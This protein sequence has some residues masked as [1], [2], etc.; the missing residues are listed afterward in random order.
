MQ[1][2]KPT[3]KVLLESA[4]RLSKPNIF[5]QGAGALDLMAAYKLL[6]EYSPRASLIPP[7]LDL[8]DCPYMWPY[9]S[10]PLYHSA[11]PVMVNVTI[12][13]GMGV[14]G[15][16]SRVAWKPHGEWGHALE[17]KAELPDSLWPWSGQMGLSLTVREEG[18]DLEDIITG[19]IQLTVQS[20]PGPGEINPRRSDLQLEVRVRVIPTPV[21][22]KRL[23]W[24]Q[25]HS[26][27]YPSAYAPRDYLG[28]GSES[29]ILDR[30][31][32]H[33]H[34]NFKSLFEKLIAAGYY[35]EILGS[36]WTCFNASQYGALLLVDSE[37]EFF[38]EEMEK[39]E[40]DIRA[41]GLSLVVFADWFS[42]TIMEQVSFV[43]DNTRILW[44]PVTGG[45]NIPA[46]NE[47]L[48]RFGMALGGQV[49]DGVIDLP[50]GKVHMASGNALARMP[51]GSLVVHTPEIPAQ[52]LP[53]NHNTL[54]WQPPIHLDIAIIGALDSNLYPPSV[55]KGTRPGVAGDNQP[56]NQPANQDF[57]DDSL[58]VQR[59]SP[60]A[61][62]SGGAWGESER[63]PQQ[64]EG[65]P[66]ERNGGKRGTPNII[67][68][69]VQHQLKEFPAAEVGQGSSVRGGNSFGTRRG[70]QGTFNEGDTVLGPGLGME[71]PGEVEV[72]SE[73]GGGAH[74][75]QPRNESLGPGGRIFLFGDS[76][77]A[78]DAARVFVKEKNCLDVFVAAVEYSCKGETKNSLLDSAAQITADDG[79]TDGA[80]LPERMMDNELHKYSNVIGESE[81]RRG[82]ARRTSNCWQ[83]PWE[84]V[85]VVE[86]YKPVRTTST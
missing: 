64:V 41:G 83:M 70:L 20:D 57:N 34:T 67:G 60:P 61:Q 30:Q 26:V 86:D 31:G 68:E 8:T 14:T 19:Q 71:A 51:K 69:G 15:T 21:R 27:S 45:A 84:E 46:L 54:H 62:S 37:E 3:S 32:D 10:Q 47:F 56:A 52:V 44:K 55:G 35:I 22:E 7:T 58:T 76:S 66:G 79:F 16:V 1:T 48:G 39:L 49:F 36:D 65:R 12:I 75:K 72:K 2:N 42:T 11:Q 6:V 29:D 82:S 28:R 4:R 17:V 38:I 80:P 63:Q 74:K 40:R 73:E 13:N 24:D 33:P 78:D 77:C 59:L 18:R 25:F 5:E 9:C 50:E 81:Y 43:D 53:G 23:L 85:V